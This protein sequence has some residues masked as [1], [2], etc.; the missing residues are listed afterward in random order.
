[1][2]ALG[3]RR[4][5]PSTLAAALILLHATLAPSGGAAEG[6]QMVEQKIKAGLIY[7]LL[8][9]VDWPD[10]PAEP[11]SATATVCIFGDD[12]LDG[13][14][15]PMAERT[16]NQRRIALRRVDEIRE[17]QH[18]HLLFVS[19]SERE[20]WPQLSAFL[21]GKSVLTVSDFR[22]F[23]GSGG[24]I[25]FGRKDQHIEVAINMAALTA[26]GLRVQDRLLK[27]AHVIPTDSP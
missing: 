12:P 13:P 27:L 2:G 19:A 4:P 15:Q 24:M 11:H 25:E 5:R 16:V 3:T 8:K 21:A 17:T 20:R 23:A 14:L 22:E 18:C 26:A 1:M 7:N 10:E 6:I 9:Y